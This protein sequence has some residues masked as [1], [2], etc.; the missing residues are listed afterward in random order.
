M[1]KED[2]QKLIG[3]YATGTLTE[4]ERLK[5]F[6]AALDDQELFD[7]L[8]QEQPLKDLFDD[9]FSREQVRLAAAEGLPGR[10][11]TSWLYRP[12]WF[13]KPW[14]WASAASVALASVLV[15]ALVRWD[16][17]PQ[18]QA[19]KQAQAVKQPEVAAN[20]QQPAAEPAP[21]PD[22]EKSASEPTAPKPRVVAGKPPAGNVKVPNPS[23][24]RMYDSKEPTAGHR[25]GDLETRRGAPERPSPSGGVGGGSGR[26]QF[27]RTTRSG[28]SPSTK[29][30]ELSKNREADSRD[31]TNER[32]STGEPAPSPR[33]NSSPAPVNTAETLRNYNQPPRNTADEPRKSPETA[34]NTVELPRKDDQVAPLPSS[35]SQLDRSQSGPSQ[36]QQPQQIQPPPPPGE[37][38]LRAGAGQIPARTVPAN[39]PSQPREADEKLR[40]TTVQTESTDEMMK[41]KTASAPKSKVVA[42]IMTPS[43]KDAPSRV[44][45][46]SFAR[47][48]DDGS[49]IVVPANTV[50][51]RGET[52]RLTVVPPDSEPFS[53]EESDAT[54]RRWRQIFPTDSDKAGVAEKESNAVPID[55]VVEKNQ[56]LRVRSGSEVRYTISI[57]TGA[58]VKG[59]AIK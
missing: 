19:V 12:S 23:D 5:L 54:N 2:I 46:Y 8:Q 57:K 27:G 35:Q 47:R 7:T 52:V 1:N 49:Y 31:S 39:P 50:F 21:Q 18:S 48:S 13:S 56:R 41:A 29:S 43:K 53:I 4:E 15:V 9:P 42:G 11:R 40:A 59:R 26:A 28:D 20:K 38:R 22:R 16:R 33:V 25:A 3:G 32:K 37:I 36:I 30:V 51:Q 34:R 58:P 14:V 55:I 17:T 44:S 6:E 24:R 45:S 10:Q